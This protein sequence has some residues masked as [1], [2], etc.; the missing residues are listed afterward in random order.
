MKPCVD[1]R[2]RTERIGWNEHMREHLERLNAACSCSM[3]PLPMPRFA[4]SNR[5]YMKLG[6]EPVPPSLLALEPNLR[7]FAVY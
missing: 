6:A 1:C 2:L 4:R 7:P 3:A 5:A